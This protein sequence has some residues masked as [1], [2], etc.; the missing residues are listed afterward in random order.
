MLAWR[1]FVFDRFY[2][3]AIA[4]FS[5]QIEVKEKYVKLQFPKK[6]KKRKKKSKKR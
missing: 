2:A 6:K 1:R 5:K 3:I 4:S